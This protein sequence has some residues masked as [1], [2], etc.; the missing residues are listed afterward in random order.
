[1]SNVELNVLRSVRDWMRSLFLVMC[2]NAML[3]FGIGGYFIAH[4]EYAKYAVREG[5]KQLE[6]NLQQWQKN[7]EAASKH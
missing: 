4:V 7:M 2:F 1:M 5:A 3:L 6:E